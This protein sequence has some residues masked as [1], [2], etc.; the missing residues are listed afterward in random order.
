MKFS[1]LSLTIVIKPLKTSESWPVLAPSL[2]AHQDRQCCHD[3]PKPHEE[4]EN[5]STR[6]SSISFVQNNGFLGLIH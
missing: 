4:E 3:I 2:L 1:L 6:A 5:Q